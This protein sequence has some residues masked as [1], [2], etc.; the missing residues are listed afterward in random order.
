MHFKTLLFVPIFLGISKAAT[1][2]TGSR[3]VNGTDAPQGKYPFQISLR[4][5][6]AHSCG[7]TILNAE[8]VLTAAYCV[9]RSAPE[10][11]TVVAGS[12]VLSEGTSHQVTE[13][14]EHEE[15]NPYISTNDIAILRVTPAFDF[16]NPSI[17]PVFLPRQYEQTVAGDVATVIGWGI[18]STGGTIQEV[19]KEVD[20]FVYCDEEC[21]DIHGFRYNANNVCAGVPGGGKGECNIPVARSLLMEHKLALLPGL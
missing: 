12:V 11:M 3:I 21:F 20:L 15:W 18:D 13:K 8:Y 10:S 6:G 4:I 16:S 5:F 7:G 17:A 19:L 14:I 9:D 1:L 2:G